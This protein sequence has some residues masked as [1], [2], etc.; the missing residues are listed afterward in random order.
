MAR[1]CPSNYRRIILSLLCCCCVCVV[2]AQSMEMSSEMRDASKKHDLQ[3]LYINSKDS[4]LRFG[5]ITYDKVTV[6]DPAKTY[7]WYKSNAILKT[8]GGADGRLLTGEYVCFYPNNNLK[9]KGTFN[10]GL[11]DGAWTSWLDN[12]QIRELAHWKKGA[13][14]GYHII[15]DQDGSTIISEKYKN[16]KLV[17][18]KESRICLL[19]HRRK[20]LSDNKTSTDTSPN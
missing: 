1:Y 3:T 19:F 9:E 13:L 4:V 18:K 15:Y 8:A 20:K 17:V 5:T 6:F 11:K 12:G 10:L 14:H 7:F 16:G 2:S